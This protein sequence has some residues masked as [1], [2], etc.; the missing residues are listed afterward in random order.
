M[1]NKI[2]LSIRTTYF[3]VRFRIK[4]DPFWNNQSH[5]AGSNCSYSLN[6]CLPAVSTFLTPAIGPANN[7]SVWFHTTE[8]NGLNPKQKIK[9]E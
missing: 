9:I 3:V 5:M 8:A 6:E 4:V 7:N 2:R 1:V